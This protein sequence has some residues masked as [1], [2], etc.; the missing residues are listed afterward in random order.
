MLD[1]RDGCFQENE[2]VSAGYLILCIY[3]KRCWLRGRSLIE[4]RVGSSAFPDEVRGRAAPISFFSPLFL[5]GIAAIFVR[6]SQFL[7]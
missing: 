1:C 5:E 6:F 2:S 4:L 3:V 7:V